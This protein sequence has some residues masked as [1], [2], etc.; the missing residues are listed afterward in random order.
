MYTITQ[1]NFAFGSQHHCAPFLS[2]NVL[3]KWW[4][5]AWSG[6][7]VISKIQWPLGKRTLII[8][9]RITRCTCSIISFYARVFWSSSVSFG[10]STWMCSALFKDFFHI[11]V[12]LRSFVRVIQYTYL[13]CSSSRSWQNF[14][15]FKLKL[16]SCCAKDF[17]WIAM[18]YFELG[19]YCT[20]NNS[21]F[22]YLLMLKSNV[23]WVE[24]PKFSTLHHF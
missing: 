15:V 11:I 23:F 17:L 16:H 14:E 13:L 24:I 19:N 7:R 22:I 8:S 5:C 3:E 4:L 2:S 10:R 6:G 12:F 21:V 20:K 9:L 18:L 1:I